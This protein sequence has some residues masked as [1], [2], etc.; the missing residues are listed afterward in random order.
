[1]CT[2]LTL[3]N[4]QGPGCVPRDR[5][6]R[7]SLYG[8]GFFQPHGGVANMAQKIP[9]FTFQSQAHSSKPRVHSMIGVKKTQRCV[10]LSMMPLGE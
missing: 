9:R 2:I 10:R 6:C 7:W 5:R 8:W 3:P 1:M 4:Y